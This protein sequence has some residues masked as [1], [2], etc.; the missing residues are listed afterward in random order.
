MPRMDRAVHQY[1]GYQ[2]TGGFILC[3]ADYLCLKFWSF[4]PILT[5]N[6]SRQEEEIFYICT[7]LSIMALVLFLDLLVFL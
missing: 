3:I 2:G 5:V 1:M 7:D 6:S 4:L